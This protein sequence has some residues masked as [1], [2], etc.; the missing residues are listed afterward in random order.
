M[1]AHWIDNADSWICPVCGFEMGN[2]NYHDAKC[3]VCGFKD[4][5]DM[6]LR[7]KLEAIAQPAE[8]FPELKDYK[9]GYR[10]GVMEFA[11]YLKENSFLCD[12]NDWFSFHAIN[13]EDDLDDLVEEFL[14]GNI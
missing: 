12:S 2:P 13:V 6:S 3:P 11:A 9:E 14:R 5:K 10:D 4:E 7:K 8:L 1:K